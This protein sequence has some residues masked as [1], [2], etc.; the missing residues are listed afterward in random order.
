MSWGSFGYAIDV[1]DTSQAFNWEIESELVRVSRLGAITAVM[2]RAQ[3]AVRGPSDGS[4]FEFVF[5]VP[6]KL[7]S[8]RYDLAIAGDNGALLSRYS[9]YLQVV[10]P[11]LS[12]RVGLARTE[13]QAGD[14]LISRLENLGPNRLSTRPCT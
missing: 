8:Y 13:L 2:D 1:A 9:E 10:R 7:G 12:V 5:G 3:G 11:K 4:G 6:S 14:V